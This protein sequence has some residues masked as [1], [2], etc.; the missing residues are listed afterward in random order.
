[1][2]DLA[3][4]RFA[5]LAAEWD[6]TPPGWDSG[7]PVHGN[8]TAMYQR[9]GMQRP[10]SKIVTLLAEAVMAAMA[11][12]RADDPNVEA[13]RTMLL[14]RARRGLLKYGVDTTRTDLA[15]VDWLRH[16]QEETLDTAV[17]LEVLIGMAKKD[18]GDE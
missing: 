8:L 4:I 7:I 10:L 5:L 6:E 14:D 2:P 12:K 16:L 9:A 15:W 17:Y 3:T 18:T 13:V 11:A 1:M